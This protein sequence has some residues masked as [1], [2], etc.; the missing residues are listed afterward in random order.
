M[1]F[2]LEIGGLKPPPPSPHPPTSLLIL[3]HRHSDSSVYA[4]IRGRRLYHGGVYLQS[5]LF[6]GNNSMARALKEHWG[7]LTSSWKTLLSMK[8][9][10]L[11]LFRLNYRILF[12][13]FD[14]IPLRF[15]CTDIKTLL[16]SR[17][18][19]FLGLLE[20]WLLPH[21]LFEFIIRWCGIYSRAAFINISALKCGVYARVAFNRVNSIHTKSKVPGMSR[22]NRSPLLYPQNALLP[23][24]TSPRPISLKYTTFAAVIP[25]PWSTREHFDPL[26]QSSS[27]KHPTQHRTKTRCYWRSECLRCNSLL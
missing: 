12:S 7:I 24:S 8:A 17:K 27:R 26:H 6:P 1:Y 4:F 5:T 3:S 19:H 9:N 18:I 2:L 20:T 10:F 21:L 23:L 16:Q 15:E 22:M 13:C 25:I 11:S 14:H